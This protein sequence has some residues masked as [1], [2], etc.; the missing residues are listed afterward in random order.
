MG[1][2]DSGHVLLRHHR[3]GRR[4]LLL[5]VDQLLHLQHRRRLR[6]PRR[7][8]RGIRQPRGAR[9]RRELGRHGGVRGRRGGR[10]GVSC[11][12]HVGR[13]RLRLL[14]VEHVEDRCSRNQTG[15]RRRR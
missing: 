1:S 12:R 11:R 3:R 8:G 15:T 9:R 7:H 4:H 6:V 13:L 2:G 10:G 5:P 14:R